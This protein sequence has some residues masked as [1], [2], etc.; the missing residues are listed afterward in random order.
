MGAERPHAPAD[1]DTGTILTAWVPLQAPSMNT[2]LSIIWSQRRI[3]TKPEVRL[4]RSHF[5]SYLPKWCLASTGPY[6]LSLDFHQPWYY[7][8]GYP[9]KQDVPNLLKSCIDALCERYGFDDSLLW[10]VECQKVQDEQQV[11]IQ[12]R[13]S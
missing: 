3:E 13:L 7:K 5:K 8:N 4:F 6:A 12:V 1:E 10:K 11:G 9:K 2:L